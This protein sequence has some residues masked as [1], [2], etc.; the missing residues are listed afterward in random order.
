MIHWTYKYYTLKHLLS[1]NF[2][3]ISLQTQPL[4]QADQFSKATPDKPSPA[5]Q[6]TTSQATSAAPGLVTRPV[7]QESG[8]TP[9]AVCMSQQAP[10]TQSQQQVLSL[11]SQWSS[12]PVTSLDT[13]WKQ[14]STPATVSLDSQWKETTAPKSSI[15]QQAS[16]PPAAVSLDSQWKG[17]S[18]APSLDD[19]WR[20]GPEAKTPEPIK[21]PETPPPD[22]EKKVCCWHCSQNNLG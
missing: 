9:S 16:D 4:S 18:A 19:Q 11:D 8:V 1:L 21:K 14:S 15:T 2:Q 13:Q 17:V 10:A 12:K 22:T 7:T 5:I 3:L 20:T 6:T